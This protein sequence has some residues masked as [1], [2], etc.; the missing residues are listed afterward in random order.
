MGRRPTKTNLADHGGS[1]LPSSNIYT[2]YW[3]NSSRFPIDLQSGLE[4]L[5]S[6]FSLGG[7]NNYSGILTQYLRDGTLVPTSSYSGSVSDSSTGPPRRGPSVNT[8]VDEAC[9]AYGTHI[10]PQGIYIVITSNFPKGANWC[11]WH[12]YGKCNGST[13][14]V[15][16]LPNVSGVSGCEISGAANPYSRATQSMANIAA[17]EWAEAVTD[18]LDNAWYDPTGHEIGDKCLWQFSGTVTLNDG[19]YPWQLQ[20]LWSNAISA[21]AQTAG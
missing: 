10:D 11:A 21:C 20:E 3:G 4:E 1:V 5:F 13:I 16:Y 6:N 2:V 19:K 7:S 17:H 15:V 8:I 9:K 14:P 18:S 12:S